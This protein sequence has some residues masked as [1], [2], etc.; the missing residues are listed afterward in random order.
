MGFQWNGL[1]LFIQLER[2]V[3]SYLMV[4]G[5]PSG[6]LW[7]VHTCEKE[8]SGLTRKCNESL[9]G[10]V[11]QNELFSWPFFKVFNRKKISIHEVMEILF[12]VEHLRSLFFT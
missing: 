8:L 12:N 10:L 9:Q 5:S 1:Q 4:S 7:L 11:V 2:I 3:P 6:M